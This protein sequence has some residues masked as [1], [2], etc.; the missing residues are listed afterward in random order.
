MG[1]TNNSNNLV[2]LTIGEHLKAHTLLYR[3]NKD[4]KKLFVALYLMSNE[5][6][7]KELLNTVD[8]KEEFEELIKD[9]SEVKHAY[10]IQG[11][12]NPMYGK[13][14]TKEARKLMSEKK[15]GMYFGKENPH[16][17]KKHTEEMKRKLS[18]ERIGKNNPIAKK[19][20]CPELDMTFDTV[21][22]AQNYVGI[23]SGVIACCRKYGN[24]ETAGRHPQTNEKLH[25]VYVNE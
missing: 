23:T 15:R 12:N 1:G 18:I 4:N 22:E 8:S 5:I 13:H 24:R 25:W 11:E 9:I 20:Y 16:W 10:N 17:G 7:I 2:L 6:E 19:V 3:E 21:K 14:H